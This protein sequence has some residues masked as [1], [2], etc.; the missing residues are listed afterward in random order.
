MILIFIF[1]TFFVK[2]YAVGTHHEM[3]Q[4]VFIKN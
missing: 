4:L 3:P 2:I 1:L